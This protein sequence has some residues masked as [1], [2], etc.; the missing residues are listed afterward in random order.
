MNQLGLVSQLLF[1]FLLTLWLF[2][3]ILGIKPAQANIP[4]DSIAIEIR[5][6]N[7]DAGNHYFDLYLRKVGGNKIFLG[8]SDI[9]IA[10][11]EHSEPVSMISYLQGS[12][13][14]FANTGVP[15]Y[16]YGSGIASKILFRNGINQLVINV[17]GPSFDEEDFNDEVAA[18]D[19]RENLHRLGRFAISG[20][21]RDFNLNGSSLYLQ[22]SGVKHAVF[23]FDQ[24]DNF[25]L[26]AVQ[27]FYSVDQQTSSNPV[28]SFEAHKKNGYVL[29]NWSLSGEVAEMGIEKSFDGKNW[30]AVNGA[31]SQSELGFVVEDL[32]P[33]ESR[34]LDVSNLISYRLSVRGEDGKS[35]FSSVKQVNYVKGISMLAYPNPVL[36]ELHIRFDDGVLSDFQVQIISANGQLI[37][38]SAGSHLQ[39]VQMDLRSL[40]NGNYIVRVV[41]GSEIGISRIVVQ[42]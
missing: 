11:N 41:A 19:A 2:A 8:A 13:Q 9:V 30:S 40:A 33:A 5:N 14:L 21:S 27:S 42:K 28:W 20:V 25:K 32:N 37:S 39:V 6:S 17:Y 16:N 12:S 35:Y 38:Q 15:V 24:A 22:G 7:Y 26:K 34:L 4:V 10:L 36:D 3:L 1:F 23:G 29:L 18:I 31:I